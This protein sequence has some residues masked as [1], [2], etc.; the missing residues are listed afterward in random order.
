MLTNK[1]EQ[2]TAEEYGEIASFLN[3]C[4]GARIE[5]SPEWLSIFKNSYKL[6]TIYF[7]NKINN[8][9]SAIC[10]ITIIP[11]FF[12]KK[13]QLISQP[14]LAAAGVLA[15]DH[16]HIKILEISLLNQLRQQYPSSFIEIRKIS[17][18]TPT[19][20]CTWE[21]ELPNSPTEMINSFT[22][23]HRR[24][25]NKSLRTDFNVHFNDCSVADTYS[26]Y[27]DTMKR[28]GLPPHPK[29][30][31]QQ[32]D[33]HFA[34]KKIVLSINA[35]SKLV[36]CIILLPLGN[37][38]YAPFIYSSKQYQKQLVN[39]R[40]YWEAICFAINKEF[41]FLDL[42]RSILGTGNSDFKRQW[43]ATPHC[44]DTITNR[45]G[46]GSSQSNLDAYLSMPILKKASTIWSYLP[47]AFQ[48]SLGPKIRKFIV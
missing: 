39:Y 15:R 20:F 48:K 43:A 8:Q 29:T 12:R 41:A 9:L 46:I 13:Q 34:E 28:H 16:K 37:K 45:D 24:K 23:N 31:F 4:K 27:L 14:Y 11:R 21:I 19:N 30:F 26:L 17:K 2:I 3:V 35:G 6:Q 10:P 25:V 22:S 33:L 44:I 36:A 47:T 7:G 42:G 32:V 5:H 18:E 40:L 1:W 38:L